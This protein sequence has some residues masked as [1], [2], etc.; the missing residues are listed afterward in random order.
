MLVPMSKV[1]IVGLKSLFFQVLETL[2]DLG[3]LHLEDITKKKGPRY[4]D[5]IPMEM[6]PAMEEEKA[7]LQNLLMRNNAI[8]SELAPPAERISRAEIEEKYRGFQGKSLAEI[9]AMVQEEENATKELINYKNELEVEL[10]RLSKY[11]PIIKK[12]YPLASQIT[13]SEHY[14]SVA[15][16]VEERYVA[17]LDYIKAE[18]EK[19]TNK[20]CE[21]HSARVDANTHAAILVFPKRFSEQVHNFLAAENVNQVRLPSELAD[22]PYDEALKEIEERYK[23]IPPKLAKV[24]EQLDELSK[25]WYVT[26]LALKEYLSDR[27]ES[28]NAIPKFGQ[29]GHT[30][31]IVGWM[32]TE[33]VERTRQILEEK[34]QGKVELTEVAAT[35]EELEH[36]PTALRNPFWVKPFEFI[37]MLINPPKYGFTDPTFLVAIFFP[38]LFGFM[39]GDMGYALVLIGVVYL[40]KYMLKKK[41]SKSVFF[42]MF[43]N[44]LLLASISSFIFGL[45]YFEFFGDLLI[46]LFGWKDAEGHMIVKWVWGHTSNGKPWGWPLE[47]IAQANPDVFKLL[48]IIVITIG[49]LHMGSGLIIGLIDG[50]RHRDRK[51]A[52]EK[53]GYLLF[54]IGLILAFG[55][56][57]GFKGIKSFAVPAGLAAAFIGIGMAGYGGGFGG[58]LEAALTFGNLLSYARLY[59]V[60]LASVILAEVA[61]ELGAEFGGGAMVL[62]GVIVAAL[63]HTLNIALGVLSPS[64]QSLRLNLVESFTKFYKQTDV[65]YK[66]FKRAGGE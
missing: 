3:T 30:F 12:I 47:R 18:L 54:L 13:T 32:P 66:P 10:S 46:R 60:G 42:H 26:L 23:E 57:W 38:L 58:G 43:A 65:V 22:K 25:K 44:V 51:H 62:L 27:I 11:E 2:Q 16:L 34:F 64:I 53:A 37:Y 49:A 61:N 14:T 29:S 20:Q 50:I 21:V 52:I 7:K 1:E 35:H 48:L 19:I 17:V 59:G 15:L 36:A 31:V 41:G 45:L 56:L 63:L 33:E 55:S 4:A 6:D 8:L 39:L 9:E 40:M 28:L 5:L 24:R